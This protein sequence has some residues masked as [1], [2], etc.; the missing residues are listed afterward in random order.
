[1]PISRT[2]TEDTMGE[3]EELRAEVR[4]LRDRADIQDLF[5]QFAAGMDAQDWDLLERVFSD[6]IVVDH[7]AE[8]WGKGQVEDHWVGIDRV[9]DGMRT[10]VS[11]HFVS[12]HMITNHRVAIDGDRA[13]VVTYLH[14]VHLDDPQ[15]P[16]RHA[17]HGAWYLCD[18][19][20]TSSGW[21]VSR[22]KHISLWRAGDMKPTGPVT[23]AEVSEMRD[24]LRTAIAAERRR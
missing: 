3:L 21:R 23:S 4:S 14:S 10:G 5:S 24:H 17:D 22:M 6:D 16:D 18:L 7:T 15:K 12:H 11:R 9:M 20:R 1:M 19:R 13:R 2:W 8:V